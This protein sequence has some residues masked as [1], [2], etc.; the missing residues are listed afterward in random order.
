M[1]L[2]LLNVKGCD[3]NDI[4]GIEHILD[5]RSDDHDG[6]VWSGRYKPI[7]RENSKQFFESDTA[8]RG[9][10]KT[11]TE[12]EIERNEHFLNKLQAYNKL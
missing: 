6:L 3:L 11:E 10:L 5:R 4:V 2:S 12:K 7:Y 8:H 9:A 1:Y